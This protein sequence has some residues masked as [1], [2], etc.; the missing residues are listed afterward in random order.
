MEKRL[1]SPELSAE[2]KHEVATELKEIKKLLN[3]NKELLHGLRKENSKSFILTACLVFLCFL[4]YGLYVMI[5][6]Y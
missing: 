3:V 2:K 5:Y 1:E 6:G 4:I